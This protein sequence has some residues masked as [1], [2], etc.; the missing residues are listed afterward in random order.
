MVYVVGR[1][2]TIVSFN[3]C[4]SDDPRGIEKIIPNIVLQGVYDQT[5]SDRAY[6][7]KSLEG[8]LLMVRRFLGYHRR[9]DGYSYSSGTESFEVYKLQL[10]V[11]SGK[12]LQMSKVN[13]LG[14]NVLFLDDS[15]SISLSAS[16]FSNCLQK[17]SI[18]YADD[19]YDDHPTPYPSSPFDNGIYN[20][21]DQ[22][23]A[24]HYPYDSSFERMPPPLWV[25]PPF[26]WD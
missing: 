16:Y 9:E 8:D 24:K 14:D 5:Y 3:L 6:L 25:L 13:S 10:D 19:F 12:L 22:S 2:N 18:Y 1:W 26:K 23:F 7:V 21:K 17:D 4:Y 20:V 11:Q 15:D